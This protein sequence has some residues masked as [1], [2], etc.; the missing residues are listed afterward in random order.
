MFPIEYNQTY[1]GK[2][3]VTARDYYTKTLDWD[4]D[5]NRDLIEIAKVMTANE[6][7]LLSDNYFTDSENED[8]KGGYA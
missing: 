5:D 6:R 3:A 2:L 4:N 1:F 7:S 8:I